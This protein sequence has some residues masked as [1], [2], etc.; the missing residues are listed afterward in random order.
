MQNLRGSAPPENEL[1]QKPFTQS[2]SGI[3]HQH[4]GYKSVKNVGPTSIYE[5]NPHLS[6]NNNQTESW[7]D[8]GMRDWLCHFRHHLS[9]SSATIV[10]KGE[11]Q[12]LFLNIIPNNFTAGT[13]RKIWCHR[14]ILVRQIT[15]WYTRLRELS[16]ILHEYIEYTSNNKEK[17]IDYNM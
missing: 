10:R 13:K 8:R 9:T 6:H 15:G 3:S 7:C 2:T 1:I 4:L 14:G 5:R 11:N 16:I 12:H 17:L